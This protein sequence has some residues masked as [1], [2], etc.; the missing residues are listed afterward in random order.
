MNTMNKDASV[1]LRMTE[2]QKNILT[3]KAESVGLNLSAYLSSLLVD[4]EKKGIKINQTENELN[5]L[6]SSMELATNTIKSQKQ[7]LSKLTQRLKEYTESDIQ[8]VYEEVR[9][10]LVNGVEVYSLSDFMNVLAKATELKPKEENDFDINGTLEVSKIEKPAP[11]KTSIFKYLA[12]GL[13]LIVAVVV[14]VKSRNRRTRGNQE[15]RE[16]APNQDS[17]SEQR[18]NQ[19]TNVHNRPQSESNDYRQFEK[20]KKPHKEG[21]FYAKKPQYSTF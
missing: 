16:P 3:Q 10:H 21:E 11:K 20:K 2:S 13:S 19:H 6:Q 5:K 4:Y 9:N 14:W 7:D 15:Q 1:T 8:Q 18:P 17:N 12:I